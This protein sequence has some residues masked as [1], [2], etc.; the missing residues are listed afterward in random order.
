MPEGTTVILKDNFTNTQTALK[1][2]EAYSFSVTADKATYG[3]ERFLLMFNS[4]KI[5]AL[6]DQTINDGFKAEV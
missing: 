4:N 3:E 2:N 6:Q 5:T 1:L